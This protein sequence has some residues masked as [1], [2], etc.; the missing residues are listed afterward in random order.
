MKYQFHKVRGFYKR[1]LEKDDIVLI[2]ADENYTEFFLESGKRFILAKTLKQCED[3]F[4]EPK[5]FRSHRS[6]IINL[7]HWQG[8]NK[9]ELLL[10]NNLFAKI[11]RRKKTPFVERLASFQSKPLNITS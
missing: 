11:S 7:D 1:K 2:K 10:S 9:D 3:I 4:E 6:F 8:M 5:F